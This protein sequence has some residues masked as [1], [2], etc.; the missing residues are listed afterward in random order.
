M[1]NALAIT[2]LLVVSQPLFAW[3]AKGH[4]VV[5]EIA[6]RG[7]SPNVAQRVRELTF[8]APLRD[9]ASMPDDWRAQETRGE[10]PGDTGPL[11]YS[12]IPNDQLT[13]DRA[14]DCKEDQCVVAA[15]EKYTAVLKDKTQPKDKR[16]EALIFL[17][18]FVGDIHQPLHAAGGLVKN[19]QTGEPEPDLGGNRVK[20][21]Y[22]GVETNLHS[23]WDS[24][25]IE[26][27]PA[28]VED[29]ATHLLEDEIRGRPIEELQRGTVVD[30]INESHYAAIHDGYRI[31][32]GNIGSSYA[33]HNIGV[34]YERLLRAGLRLRK[35]LE[36]TL[37]GNLSAEFGAPRAESRSDFG[38][39]LMSWMI[40][41]FASVTS[42]SR[43]LVTARRNS[44]LE[45]RRSRKRL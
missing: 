25:L 31:G 17:V 21:R 30:W 24:M 11:H 8:A 43:G 29:Y 39:V 15:I 22:L 10:R 20:V 7:L 2:L 38:R 6:D 18:H 3:G 12:N 42:R 32:N 45:T 34:I 26:W 33:Q 5:A 13:F 14:R 19:E 9:V 37:G 36:E 44:A 27:G 41:R 40:E 1:R 16:R 28:T 23:M 4:S 35:L